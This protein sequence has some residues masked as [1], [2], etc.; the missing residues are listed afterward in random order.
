VPRHVLLLFLG[1]TDAAEKQVDE[2]DLF[3]KNAP[4]NVVESYRIARGL[5]N[6]EA[7][8]RD[9][10][11]LAHVAY[12]LPAGGMVLVRPDGY[13]GYRSNDFDP[14]KLKAYFGRLFLPTPEAQ[15]RLPDRGAN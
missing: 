12:A 13:I 8:L 7:E 2:I 5:T 4:A 3:L 11:G 14:F 9:V 6:M 10:S 1:A 15:V